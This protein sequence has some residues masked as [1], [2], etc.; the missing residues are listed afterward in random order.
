MVTMLRKG[1]VKTVN[2][3][4]AQNSP[5]VAVIESYYRDLLNGVYPPMYVNCIMQNEWS[6]RQFDLYDAYCFSLIH[7]AIMTGDIAVLAVPVGDFPVSD[8]RY[9]EINNMLVHVPPPFKAT[10]HGGFVDGADGILKWDRPVRAV[11]TY[12]NEGQRGIVIV[13]P[14]DTCP[15]EVGSTESEK[16]ATYLRAAIGN[17]GEFQVARWPYN[18]KYIYVLTA[19]F[20]TKERYGFDKLRRQCLGLIGGTL[21]PFALMEQG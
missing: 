1:V 19:D 11:V 5:M 14:S 2:N 4:I 13:P 20:F 3:M 16:T 12:K 10:F 18:S 17:G 6:N 21:D 7:A 15:L 8:K 9:E